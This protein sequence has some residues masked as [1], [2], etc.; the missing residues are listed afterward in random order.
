MKIVAM[1]NP[2]RIV[3]PKIKPENAV[4]DLRK[5]KNIEKL[6]KV[7][8]EFDVCQSDPK[9][10]LALLQIKLHKTE[11][12]LRQKRRN[13]VEVRKS[14]DEQWKDLDK[15]E[16]SLRE[17]FC[18]FDT[19]V[20]ENAEKRERA[21][22]KIKEDKLLAMQRQEEIN[23]CQA[24]YI[25]IK[26]AKFEMD[27]KIKEY[28]IY[29]EFLDKVIETSDEF[30]SNQDMIN[31]Y[32]S[33]LNAKNYLA[34]LQEDNL[35]ALET[36]RS[37]MMK[38]IEEKNFIIMG[39]NNQIANLQSRYE[40]ANIKALD[41]E[42]SVIHIKNH[43]VRLMFEID[44]VKSSIWNVYVHMAHSKKHP[45]KIKKE[46]IEEQ[47]MYIKRTLTEL[48]KVSQILKKRSKMNTKSE[49]SKSKSAE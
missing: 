12:L 19:F 6:D 24:K 3:F 25:E 39:L 44:E 17:N 29:D 49:K 42:Q 1:N 34:K 32:L 10:H 16:E 11:K 31:R 30:T 5:S 41:C 47:M 35:R 14:L 7:Y 21:S 20:R 8:P 13:L 26:Q 45:V 4:L 27:M 22:K 9:S 37:D 28:R 2:P 46:N 23:D 33:L 36:A 40:N 18:H 15:K 43:A 38:L 48:S